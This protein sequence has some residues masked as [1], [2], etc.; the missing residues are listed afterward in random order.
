MRIAFFDFDKTLLR[1]DSGRAVAW[2]MLRRGLVPPGPAARFGWNGLLYLAGLKSRSAMQRIG[3][4]TY[5][6]LTLELLVP[7]M[8]EL[9]AEALEPILSGPMVERLTEHRAA[10]DC[11]VLLTAS[12][13]FVAHPARDAL[14]LDGVEGTRMAVGDDGRLTGEPASLPLEG[15]EKAERAAH[16]ADRRGVSAAQCVAYTD[17]IIDLPLL[18]WVGTPVAVGPDRELAGVARAR[19]WEIVRHAPLNRGESSTP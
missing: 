9:W 15:R 4:A 10:G 2:P 16:W 8:K 5:A 18:E 3:Y 17:S 6:G 12:P 11:V 7:L 19:G 1:S 14:A 13:A